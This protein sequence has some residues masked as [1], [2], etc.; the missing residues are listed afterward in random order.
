MPIRTLAMSQALATSFSLLLTPSPP[1]GWRHTQSGPPT[2][3]CDVDRAAICDRGTLLAFAALRALPH[4]TPLSLPAAHTLHVA[5]ALMPADEAPEMCA[6]IF[7]HLAHLPAIRRGARRL[8]EHLTLS[9]TPPHHSPQSHLQQLLHGALS[10]PD[11]T[12]RLRAG[13]RPLHA[14]EHGL[15]LRWPLPLG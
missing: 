9:P 14:T 10:H 5:R 3:L 15:W 1:P 7:F 11:L 12:W 6:E 4:D 8:V 2:P 13:A